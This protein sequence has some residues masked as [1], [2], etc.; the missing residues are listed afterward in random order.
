[1]EEITV[2]HVG[3]CVTDHERS[4]RFYKEGLGFETVEAFPCGSR[5]APLAELPPPTRSQV[6]ILAKGGTRIEIIGWTTPAA[7]GKPSETRNQ[8][9]FTHLS[10]YVERL[11]EVEARLVSLGATVLEHTRVHLD[12]PDGTMDMVFL[13]DPDGVRIE[14]VQDTTRA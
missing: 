3:I 12:L 14:L 13:A 6:E 1:M 2:S 10:L 5:F 7:H 8:V 11:A 9:G 4:V